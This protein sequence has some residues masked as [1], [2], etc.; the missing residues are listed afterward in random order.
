MSPQKNMPSKIKKNIP[1]KI[2]TEKTFAKKK[3]NL[4]ALQKSKLCLWSLRKEKQKIVADNPPQKH[5]LR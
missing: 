2:P 4:E 1:P 3:A 5:T